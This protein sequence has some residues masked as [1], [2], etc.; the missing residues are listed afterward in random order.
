[1]SV[2]TRHSI[3][4]ADGEECE[5]TI[6]VVITSPNGLFVDVRELKTGGF[7]WFFAGH[8]IEHESRHESKQV[9]EFNHDFLDSQFIRTGQKPSV[10][11]GEFSDS[12]NETERMNGIRIEKG[13]MAN[14]ANGDVQEYKE[15]WITCDPLCGDLV[16][17]GKDYGANEVDFVVLETIEGSIV[18]NK[19]VHVGRIVKYGHWIQGVYYD[20]TNKSEGVIRKFKDKDLILHGPKS[21]WP[22]LNGDTSLFQLHDEIEMNGVIWRVVETR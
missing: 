21:I 16:Y 4:W 5:P 18:D 10:D 20:K 8:E 2:S 1:M 17:I 14:P 11:L 7:D 13:K 12:S 3:Q 19:S 9:I 15:K 22:E 6:T